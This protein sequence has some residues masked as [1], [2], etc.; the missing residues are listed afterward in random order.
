MKKL[1]CLLAT[2]CVF[3][4]M[5]F[6]NDRT[7]DG[8]VASRNVANATAG[9]TGNGNTTSAGAQSV[10]EAFISPA[11][12][13]PPNRMVR[14]VGRSAYDPAEFLTMKLQG[15]ERDSGDNH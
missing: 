1:A 14:H 12:A 3:P 7:E 15:I 5:T 6:A 11:G 13:D 9:N 4:T 2:L 10:D 8:T